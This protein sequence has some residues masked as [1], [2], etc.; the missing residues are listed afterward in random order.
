MAE[1]TMKSAAYWRI[2]AKYRE[3]E[4]EMART[5]V[6]NDQVTPAD[7][8]ATER[9]EEW[10]AQQGEEMAGYAQ[11]QAIDAIHEYVVN[12]DGEATCKRGKEAAG[13]IIRQYLE[14]N[15]ETEIEDAERGLKAILGTRRVGKDSYDVRSMTQAQVVK[16]WKAGCLLVD[17]DMLNQKANAALRIDAEPFV[18]P[19]GE[20]TFLRVV[21]E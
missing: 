7:A 18:I 10:F 1:P 2:A 13:L 3:Q 17:P 14:L 15:N 9:A 5:R 16:L 19:A 6:A 11:R 4:K 20:T 21:K 8:E 12:R